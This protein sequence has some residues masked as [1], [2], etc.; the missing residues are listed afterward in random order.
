[1]KMKKKEKKTA[2]FNQNAN[3]SVNTDVPV[4]FYLSLEAK[5]KAL[6]GILENSRLL[7]V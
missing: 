4:L 1:M 2:S 3:T 7:M 6:C 5:R